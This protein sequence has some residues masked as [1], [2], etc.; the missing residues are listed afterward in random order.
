MQ[1][2]PSNTG[3]QIKDLISK[4]SKDRILIGT[5]AL[6]ILQAIFYK[7]KFI[8]DT[9][10][11]SELQDTGRI[12]TALNI[13]ITSQPDSFFI[14]EEEFED[15]FGF[16]RPPKDKEVVFYCKAGVRCRAAAQLARQGGWERTGEYAGSW[17]DWAAKGGA[18]ER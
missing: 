11:P 17:L 16:D 14:S 12:P 13:P 15:R 2:I 6:L 18:V 1:S 5:L 3:T 7:T 8:K 4:P 9:R 10:E